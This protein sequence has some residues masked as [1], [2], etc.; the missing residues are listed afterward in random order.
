[1]MRFRILIV[2][3]VCLVGGASLADQPSPGRKYS[4][5]QRMEEAHLSAVH[6][7]RLNF[8]RQRKSLPRLGVYNDYRAVMHVHAEDADHTKGTRAEVLTAAKA[9]GVSVVMFTDH[10][11]PKPETWSGMRDGVLFIPGSEDDH[12]LRFPS[13]A[14]DLRFLSHLEEVPDAKSDGFQGMEIYNRHTDAKDEKA[15]D[16]YFRAAMKNPVEWASLVKRF[17]RFPDEV[18]AAGT[19]Y[20]DSF[21]SKWDVE[22]A[23]HPFTGVAA[24]DS[25]KNQTFNG[26]TFDPYEVSFR[27]A[28]THI[29]A[30]DLS[31]AAIRESLRNG[32]AYVSHDWLVDPTGFAFGAVNNNGVY[33]MG[34]RA[35]MI[36]RTRLMATLPIAANIRIIHK[37]A[38]VAEANDSAINFTPTEPGAY[39][40]EAWLPV[41]GEMRPWIY[42]N[43]VYLEAVAGRGITLPSSEISPSVEV[44]KDITYVDGQLA[45]AGKH[46]LD[47]YLPRDKTNFPVLI[48]I[49]GGSWRSGDRS[50]YPALGNRF[51]RQGIGVVVPSYRLMPGAPHPAQ[52]EDATAAVDWVVK[53]IAEHGG[54]A[55][56]IY[57]SGHSAGG[58]LAAFAGLDRRYWPNLKGVLALSGVYDV[59]PLPAFPS[60]KVD[61]SPLHR[62]AP[63]A[64]PFLITYC[65]NDYPTL[66]AEAGKFHAALQAAGVSSELVYI[67]NKNH[68]SEI[69][70]IWQDDDPTAVAILK[71]MNSH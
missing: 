38:T 11:G 16:D 66:P 63:G 50:N 13:S 62:I 24:N 41:D 12:L 18:F 43:P 55:R 61:G 49:H 42:A 58:H 23:A 39:R 37:G 27:N 67:P 56:R 21:I 30:R 57:L 10:R 54:D 7:A 19:D 28:S 33:D 3:G 14:G 45:D 35:P 36:A 32:R 71:F 1:M 26:V 6:E 34:D 17:D 22:N 20:L 15:F 59:I 53:N 31:E 60:D 5:L 40:L 48:F 64:P 65:Q 29:L 68:I 69:V 52:V 8:A 4:T 44:R 2:C 51:A 9:T 70:D 25:H 46:K 47:L